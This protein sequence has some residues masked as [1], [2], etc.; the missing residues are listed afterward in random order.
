M[1]NVDGGH[2][3]LTLLVP[4]RGETVTRQDGSITAASHALREALACLPTAAQST[5]SVASRR[6]SPFSRCKRTHFARLVVLD[7][8]TFNGRDPTNA[9]V[10]SLRKTD[11]LAHQPVDRLTT[12]WL[13][14]GADFDVTDAPDHGLDHYLR[15]L[16]QAMEPEMRA[17]FRYCHGFDQV[18]SAA[19]FAGYLKRC[20]VETTMPFNDYWSVPFVPPSMSLKQLGGI[21]IGLSVAGMALAW[22]VL[23]LLSISV[24]WLWLALP[25]TLALALGITYCLVMRRG[26]RP[27]PTAP[28]CDLPSVLKALYL[29]QA[30]ARFAARHQ[31][32]DAN[33]LHAAFGDFLAATRPGDLTGPTRE[34]GVMA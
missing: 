15:H 19:D 16:W 10:Q 12:P 11:L 9:I 4:V 31:L 25:V 32:D 1:P 17:I 28:D 33:T 23:G 13:V 29:Q 3:F 21:V 34:P 5:A 30:F 6:R 26:A 14:M 24:G 20:Q 2:Y 18:T 7:Q 22:A 8:P 27:F